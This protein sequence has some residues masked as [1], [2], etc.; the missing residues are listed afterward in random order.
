MPHVERQNLTDKATECRLEQGLTAGSST[1][2]PTY[3]KD[4][5]LLAQ[6]AQTCRTWVASQIEADEWPANVQ[7]VPMQFVHGE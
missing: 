6:F 2:A 1:E 3:L 4:V 5:F 7:G